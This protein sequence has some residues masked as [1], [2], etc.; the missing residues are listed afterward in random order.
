MET[1]KYMRH[2]NN[3]ITKDI[4]KYVI[5]EVF[6]NSRYLF[7]RREGRKQF[8]YCTHCRKEFDS[9]A[10]KLKHQATYERHTAYCSLQYAPPPSK[11][12]ICPNCGSECK[13]KSAGISRKYMADIA[14]FLYYDKSRIDPEAIVARGFLA[15]RDYSGDYRQVKTEYLEVNRYLFQM[16][17]S[18]M[19]RTGGYYWDMVFH[20]KDSP[21]ETAASVYSDARHYKYLLSWSKESLRLAAQGTPFEYSCWDNYCNSY[22][23]VEFLDNFSRYPCIE[24]LTKLGFDRVVKDKLSGSRTYSAIN[25]RGKD[26]TKVLKLS[27]SEIKELR[28]INFTVDCRYLYWSRL[29]RKIDPSLSFKE[30]ADINILEY[31][32]EE[33][34]DMAKRLTIRKAINY[35][36]KQCQTNPR[37]FNTTQS[38]ITTWRDY[39]ADCKKLGLNTQDKRVAFP[40]KLHN[41][42][43]NTLKQIKIKASREMD[44]KIA[45][46]AE[47]MKKLCF[48]HQGLAIRPAQNTQELIDEGKALNHCVGTYAPSYADGRITLLLLREETQ[49]DAPFFTVEIRNTKLE[50]SQARGLRNCPPDEKVKK[51]LEAYEQ[52]LNK[53]KP[54]DKKSA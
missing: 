5:D 41:A 50:I 47:Q 44:K 9:T 35:I 42:H 21:W 49:P 1:K 15:K 27:K 32:E 52:H 22:R 36:N 25:W 3:R 46:Q 24:Y 23:M 4:K 28:E 11:P 33:F 8:A 18:K 6:I 45:A 37:I 14:Y 38:V 29:L 20:W 34:L 10:L 2:F 54:K 48:R 30:I 17:G 16:G 12:V 7:L 51:F 13:P 31:H 19:F 40:K 53:M 43:Q 39:I 26:I